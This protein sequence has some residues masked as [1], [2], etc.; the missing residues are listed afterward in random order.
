MERGLV[1]KS[2]VT[3]MTYWQT[4]KI[5]AARKKRNLRLKKEGAYGQCLDCW[6]NLGHP[7]SKQCRKCRL[8]HM[9]GKNSPAWKG[10]KGK[11]SDGYVRVFCP[12]HPLAHNNQI[13]EHRLVMEKHLGRYLE[14]YETVHH[15]NGIKD[16]NRIE[17]L[18]LMIVNHTPG[19]RIFDQIIWAKALL[20]TYGVNE[21]KYK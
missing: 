9:G 16:D 15:K 21:K 6:G 11:T 8:K 17:N 7:N 12:D 18:E 4:P 19:Q 14:P 1:G 3:K 13:K 2:M 10:G 20:S 5:K